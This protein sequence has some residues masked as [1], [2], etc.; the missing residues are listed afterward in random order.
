MNA[1]YIEA[2]KKKETDIDGVMLRFSGDTELYAAC[3]NDFLLDQTMIDLENAIDT[4]SWDDA[5][6][7][8]HAI[9]GLAGNMGFIPLFHAAAELVIAIRSNRIEEIG[10]IYSFVKKCY[11]DITNV[12][13][14]NSG[15]PVEKGE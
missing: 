2:L 5:F 1:E 3:L 11:I 15:I 9:K 6:T 7:A 4:R 14:T 12:I 13:R 8:A 10:E